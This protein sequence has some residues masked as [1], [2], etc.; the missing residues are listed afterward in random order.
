TTWVARGRAWLQRFS[1]SYENPYRRTTLRR[2]ER[3][4]YGFPALLSTGRD[5]ALLTESGLPYGAPAGHLRVTRPGR[6]HV[7]GSRRGWRVAV[8]GSL[9]TIVGSD[10]PR[11]LGRRSKS[12]DPGWID[13]GRA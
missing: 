2:A 11:A 8:I 1:S 3:R 4:R 7:R 10:L 12:K 5:W 9:S 13:P 6:L